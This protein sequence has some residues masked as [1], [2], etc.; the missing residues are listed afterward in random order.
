MEMKEYMAPEMDV[1]EMKYTKALL[2]GSDPVNDDD[3]VSGGGSG[4]PILNPAD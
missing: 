1:I 4:D 2:D 3:P